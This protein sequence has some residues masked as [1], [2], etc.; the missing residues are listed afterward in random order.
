MSNELERFYYDIWTLKSEG[1]VFM[2]WSNIVHMASVYHN[3][4]QYQLLTMINQLVDL[5][6]IC[7]YTLL[8]LIE[9]FFY[10]QN[11]T[12]SGCVVVKM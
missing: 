9:S 7:V 8:N 5:V 6:S 11:E 3:V 2:K 12:A 10:K 4:E 1:T